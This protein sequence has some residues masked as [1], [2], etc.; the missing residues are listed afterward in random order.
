MTY[1]NIH[2]SL[3]R[4]EKQMQFLSL[5]CETKDK[6]EDTHTNLSLDRKSCTFCLLQKR[7]KFTFKNHDTKHS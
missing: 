1:P 3:D 7:N 2:I 4:T 6:C 5:L